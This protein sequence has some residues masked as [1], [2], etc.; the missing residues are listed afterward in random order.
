MNRSAPEPVGYPGAALVHA[1]D[2]DRIAVI[3]ALRD[4]SWP[5]HFALSGSLMDALKSLGG[6]V[7]DE[8]DHLQ[9]VRSRIRHVLS[10]QDNP[11]AQAVA[12][13][14]WS[15]QFD[16]PYEGA[17][18]EAVAELSE[19]DSKDLLIMAA[20]GTAG[21]NTSFF[22]AILILELAAFADP[23]LGAIIARWTTLPAPDEVFPQE[24]IRTYAHAYIALGRLACPLSDSM[25]TGSA[26][27]DALVAARAVLY[28]LNRHDLSMPER[29]AASQNTLSVLLRHESG[30]AAGVLRELERAF[31]IEGLHR[32]PGT[33][34]VHAVIGDVFREE[35]AEICRM[36]LQ[37]PEKQSGY[38][39]HSSAEDS[40]DF[41]ATA[42]GRWGNLAD[43]GLLRTF[44]SHQEIG[45]AAISAIRIIEQ[46]LSV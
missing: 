31:L 1:G 42:L 13:G 18:W 9:S 43:T 38:F 20:K 7:D 45:A 23:G 44:S 3:D 10:D 15:A 41:A 34:P 25:Q 16:H 33:E 8:A 37:F 30:V 17:Y 28:W 36:A 39:V 2:A 24:V 40:I 19:E 14:V 11:D 22:T 21:D 35:V 27:Q 12:C 5:Q 29:Q 46:R 4:L 32:L 6:L 26:A